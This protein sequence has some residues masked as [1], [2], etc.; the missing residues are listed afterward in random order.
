MIDITKT[1]NPQQKEAVLHEQGPLLI[2][3]GAGSGKTKTL[4]H[5]IAH[6]IENKG[7]EPEQILAVTFTN[8]AANEMRERIALILNRHNNRMFLPFA[9]TFHSICV[10][11]LR[12]DGESIGI[13]SNF[14]IFDS[15]DQKAAI[16][17]AMK[18][19]SI[20]TK[21]HNPS[22]IA[23]LI[24][25][26][27]NEMIEIEDYQASAT[28]ASQKVA[29]Q[30]WPVYDR[31]LSD[32]KA[33]DFDDLILM[34]VKMLAKDKEVRKRWQDQFKHIMI[35]EYQDTNTVQYKLVELLTN[36]AKNICV[37]GDDWQSI[38][39]WRGADFRN[40]LNFE[41]NYPNALVV[42]LEQN[43]RST[44]SILD[45]AHMIITKNENRSKKELWTALGEGKPVM[46][47]GQRNDTAEGEFIVR[48]I[49]DGVTMG[50]RYSD[51][52]VLYR[53][54]AQSRSLE[55]AFLRYGVPYKIVGGVRFYSRAEVK[56]ILS[57]VRLVFQPEELTS[58]NRIVN[59]PTRGL[60][61][62]SVA[63]FMSWRL[64]SG[65]TLSQAL[66]Q[67][68][69]CEALSP[70]A[71]KS[72][73]NLADIL[74]PLQQQIETLSVSELIEKIITKTDFENYLDDGSI[75]AQARIENVRE[76][77]SVASE[78][79][80]VGIEGFLEEVTLM[81]DIDSYQENSDSVTL[82]T[83]HAAKGLEFPVVFMSGMEESIFPHSRAF[84]DMKELEE[85]RRL[86]YVGMT[87]AQEELVLTYAAQRMLFG[88]LQH[89]PVSRFLSDI[90]SNLS[91]RPGFGPASINESGW[92]ED[93]QSNVKAIDDDPSLEIQ[94]VVG[95]RVG[96]QIFGEGVIT[97]LEGET[98]TIK[99]K[100]RGAKKMNIVYAP[101]QKL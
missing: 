7:V 88:S 39:S 41:K 97:E 58:F 95:D 74:I 100:N 89:N 11:L 57:Y 72:F 40:I 79:A 51:H 73:A 70:K 82:M 90:D 36:T 24:S 67:V 59:K 25:S 65:L 46:I 27:K 10:R 6:L 61:A 18:E 69:S 64:A 30:V 84:F 101:L 99:F 17:A 29:A 56:D 87:R 2:L 16:K 86:C 13:A 37:V 85:E 19:L 38:Y 94:V 1:L 54:N 43:Y 80:E 21:E 23:S 66:N 15:D 75:Q 22:T 96:H 68:E 83:L 5:R 52:A 31:S 50:R 60:G 8:K 55:E 4:T 81:S 44:K 76:L 47:E 3:A 71:R 91:S 63:K 32:A 26:A 42:K 98:A 28:V 45:A 14:I 62:V 92:L 34:T 93:K 12:L 78:Y 35:D 48:S 20:D 49:V 77:I 9:G 33:L 53:T